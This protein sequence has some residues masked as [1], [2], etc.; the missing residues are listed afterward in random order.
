MKEYIP[1]KKRIPEE[2]K[3][4]YRT[5]GYW[6]VWLPL[7]EKYGKISVKSLLEFLYL[8][9]KMSMREIAEEIGQRK[10]GLTNLFKKFGIKARPKGGK[11]NK[12]GV[13]RKPENRGF[14][15][16]GSRRYKT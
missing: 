14:G 6:K 7:L 8:E 9:R 13:N 2:D 12:D 5:Y 11:N 15:R 1:K 4:A 16:G 10:N 3:V